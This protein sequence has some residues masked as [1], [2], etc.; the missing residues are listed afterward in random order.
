MHRDWS[1]IGTSE[2]NSRHNDSS[3]YRVKIKKAVLNGEVKISDLS[4][5]GETLF[6]R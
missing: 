2:D 6:P 3:D 4:K 1:N 5:A